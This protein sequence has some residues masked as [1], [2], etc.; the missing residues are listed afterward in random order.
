[1]IRGTIDKNSQGM[2]K[3]VSNRQFCMKY[4]L[5]GEESWRKAIDHDSSD[6][7]SNRTS[8]ITIRRAKKQTI[9]IKIKIFVI[10]ETW[11]VP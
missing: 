8:I 2:T 6:I 4:I 5:G 9:K 7:S 3:L 10:K 11:Q 1:M